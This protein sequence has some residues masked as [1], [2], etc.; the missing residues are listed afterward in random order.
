MT[1]GGVRMAESINMPTIAYFLFSLKNL[2]VITPIFVKKSTTNGNSKITPNVKVNIPTK[3]I[4]LLTVIM[5]S[6]KSPENPRR[7]FMLIGM[8]IK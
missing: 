4:Y 7:N 1:S 6:I 3:D 8:I 2:G 5:G